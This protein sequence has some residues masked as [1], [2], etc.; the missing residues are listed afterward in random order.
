MTLFNEKQVLA[1]CGGISRFTLHEWR[2]KKGFPRP[3]QVAGG[4]RNFWIE[5]DV[6][7]W[8][9]QKVEVAA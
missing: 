9:I 3:V 1:K 5:A 6:E 2:T 4:A 8:L 7:K